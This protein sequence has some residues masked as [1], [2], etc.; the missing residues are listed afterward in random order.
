MAIGAKVNFLKMLEKKLANTLTVDGMSKLLAAVSDVSE[1]FE[2]QEITQE[3]EHDDMIECFLNAMTVQGRSP[4][5]IAG[6][7]GTLKRLMDG[8]KVTT[9]NVT[10]Y[11]L[12]NYIAAL[13]ERGLKDTTLEGYRQVFSSFFGWLFREGLIEK[14]PLV[15]L[16]AIKT[17]KVQKMVFSEVDMEKMRQSCKTIRDK[18]IICFLASSGCRVGELVKV[19][20][21]DVDLEKLECIVHGK[22]NKERV[23]YLDNVTAMFIKEYLN[24]REDEDEA[25]FVNRYGRKFR[26]DGIREM[27]LRVEVIAKIQHIHPHKLRR[28]LATKLHK[29]GMPIQTIAAI[30]GHDHIETTMKYIVMDREDV[31]LKYKQYYAA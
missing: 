29:R 4:L 13:K 21:E 24:T 28:T 19:K 22:G 27:L 25:L 9:R 20:K 15:N 18:A 30:L 12:R 23:V 14:N 6:Y 2:M 7:R 26:E 8:I 1:H 31:K 3:Q 17:P 5:T 11:H 10:V 16:G